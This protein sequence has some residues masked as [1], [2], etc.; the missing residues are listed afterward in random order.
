MSPQWLKNVTF[1]NGLQSSLLGS[2]SAISSEH[3]PSAVLCA[4]DAVGGN[5][6]MLHSHWGRGGRRPGLPRQG[7]KCYGGGA[8]GTSGALELT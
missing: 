4:E 6:D 1:R 3:Q 7:N 2:F 8:T 5:E